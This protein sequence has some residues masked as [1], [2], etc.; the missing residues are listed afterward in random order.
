MDGGDRDGNPFVTHII[1]REVMLLSRWKAADLYLNDI[2][3]LI[4]ELS[5]TRCNEAV[6]SLAGEDEHEPYRA[7]LKQL[8]SL[9]TDT[10]A[11]LDGKIKGQKIAIKAPLQQVEQLWDPLYACY[12][13]LHQCG[14]GIIAE[15][16]LL[17]YTAPYQSLWGSFGSFGYSPRKYTPLGCIIRVNPLSGDWR[18]QS[19]E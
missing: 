16:S 18:L 14:M 9:L 5:M 4:S 8:R 2:N 15:G 7:I 12:Q 3:E 1:T 11:I 10:K 6:R 19:L 17:G 13:S